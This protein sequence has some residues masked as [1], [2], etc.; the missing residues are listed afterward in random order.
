[1]HI[2]H[3]E[4]GR[5]L[6]GG[7][8]QVLDLLAG[9][10]ARGVDSTLACPADSAIARA[11][12]DAGFP[13][14]TRDLSGD[15]DVGFLAWLV[16]LART[17]RPDVLHAHSRRG[18]DFF[19]GIAARVAG[20]PAVLTRRVDSPDVPL[21]GSLKYRPYARVVAISTAVRDQLAAEGVPSEKL[22]VIR[23]S[24]DAA[25]CQPTWPRERFL[26]EFDLEAGQRIVAVVAQL[27]PRK[28]H[29]AF[30]E[31][32]PMIRNRCPD[33]RLLLFG[34]GPLEAELRELAGLGGTVRFAGFRPDLRA[35][36]GHVDLLVHPATREGLGVALLEAQAA[37]VPVAACRVGGVPE[38]VLHGVTGL[39]VPAGD[40]AALAGEVV[41]LLDDPNLRQRLGAA[42]RERIRADYGAG[43]MAD[44]YG[45]LYREV[46]GASHGASHG[47]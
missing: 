18:A 7:P 35:F 11:A 15:L 38:A 5:H 30:L 32:W 13:T 14:A 19:G 1:M 23:S 42:A 41:R 3:L 22:A 26:A 8:R 33:A 28:G 25:A 34:T 20:V 46:A 31:A 36:L 12:A 45:A 4:T 27:I 40:E 47:P 16:D 6:Y 17:R 44:A 24:V 10:K 2:L 43:A 29:R 9:L 39:L 21:L 37:G